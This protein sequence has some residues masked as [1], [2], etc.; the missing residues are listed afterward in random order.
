M[1]PA[2]PDTLKHR[3]Y[4]PFAGLFCDTDTIEMSQCK[5]VGALILEG[6]LKK[7]VVLYSVSLN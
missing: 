7:T 2:Q 4:S 3:N 5:F 6:G 1:Q